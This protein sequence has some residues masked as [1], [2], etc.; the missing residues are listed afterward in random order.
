MDQQLKDRW[1]ETLTEGNDFGQVSNYNDN[2]DTEEPSYCALGVLMDIANPNRPKYKPTM[3][4]RIRNLRERIGYW[5]G[6]KIAGYDLD[7]REWDY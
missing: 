5:V 6:S 4:S 1:L 3:H 7:Y 2:H